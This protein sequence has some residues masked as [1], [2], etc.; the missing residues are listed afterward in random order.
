MWIVVCFFIQILNL[1]V[2]CVALEIKS[3]K[4]ELICSSLHTDLLYLRTNQHCELVSC[5]LQEVVT[6]GTGCEIMPF[7]GATSEAA[8]WFSTHFSE[9]G[10]KAPP[11]LFYVTVTLTSLCGSSTSTIAELV[12]WKS[13]H[14]SLLCPSS[15]SLHLPTWLKS[16]N[17]P[18]TWEHCWLMVTVTFALWT[19]SCDFNDRTCSLGIS[20]KTV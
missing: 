10:M 19:K 1:W 8:T 9:V 16:L 3:G 7:T 2:T 14:R 15:A 6:V 4:L 20:L 17:I 11:R 5:L 13:G 12:W 18:R